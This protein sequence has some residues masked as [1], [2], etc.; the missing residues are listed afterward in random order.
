MSIC[1]QLAPDQKGN[2]TYL[3]P[4]FYTLSKKKKIKCC[5]CLVMI[6]VPSSYSLNIRRLVSMKDLK[7]IGLRFHDC[8]TLM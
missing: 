5:Q 6:K 4:A 3:P 8:H 7:L 2:D 1:E